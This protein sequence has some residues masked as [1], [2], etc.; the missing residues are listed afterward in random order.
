MSHYV[1]V[2]TKEGFKKS[3]RK[4]FI[5]SLEE[6]QHYFFEMER[7]RDIFLGKLIKKVTN[8]DGRTIKL[9]IEHT[10][11]RKR[12]PTQTDFD[13]CFVYQMFEVEK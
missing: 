4:I 2:H 5:N 3:D 8:A 6:G 11:N 1:Q 12:I 9:V 7:V 10:Y 13:V